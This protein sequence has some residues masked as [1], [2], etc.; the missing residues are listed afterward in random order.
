MCRCAL[1][2]QPP[3]ENEQGSTQ[4]KAAAPSRAA[5]VLRLT[6]QSLTH[7]KS[8][9]GSYHRSMRA[10]LGKPEAITATAHK[11]ARILYT[12]LKN[13]TEYRPHHLWPAPSPEAGVS[14]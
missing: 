1:A 6:A 11:L 4:R 3:N 2:K 7:S 12:M 9:L 13:Q 14:R 8:S 10:R 5:A